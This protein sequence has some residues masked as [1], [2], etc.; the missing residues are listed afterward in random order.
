MVKG[1][2]WMSV[3]DQQNF[4]ILITGGNTTSGF[5]HRQR[6]IFTAEELQN[7]AQTVSVYVNQIHVALQLPEKWQDGLSLLQKIA[8]WSRDVAPE[9]QITQVHK[10]LNNAYIKHNTSWVIVPLM[11]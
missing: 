1:I 10:Q 11:L 5:Y 8:D 2:C 9:Q 4:K 6:Q 7:L 3:T